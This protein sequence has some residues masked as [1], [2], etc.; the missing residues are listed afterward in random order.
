MPVDDNPDTEAEVRRLVHR[1]EQL[2]KD[3]DAERMKR[4]ALEKE[5]ENAKADMESTS[6]AYCT[7]EQRYLDHMSHAQTVLN[8][9]L[10]DHREALGVAC[11][12]NGCPDPTEQQAPLMQWVCECSK[13]RSACMSCISKSMKMHTCSNG[14]Q[15][16]GFRCPICTTVATRLLTVAIA[17]VQPEQWRADYQRPDDD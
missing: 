16:Y 15:H 13:P 11:C 12:V 7:L 17:A 5:V 1:M 4:S 8:L 9:R 6:D 2:Q 14:T 3:L 10:A